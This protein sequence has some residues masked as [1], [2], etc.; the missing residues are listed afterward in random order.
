MCIGYNRVAHAVFSM[1]FLRFEKSQSNYVNVVINLNINGIKRRDFSKILFIFVILTTFNNYQ[2][3]MSCKI[4]DCF[5]NLN[6]LR[7]CRFSYI[8]R[9]GFL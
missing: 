8:D 2:I 1:P 3:N 7:I 4:S 6:N 9:S 5:Y